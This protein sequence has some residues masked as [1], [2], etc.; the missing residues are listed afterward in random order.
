MRRKG[1][2]K[3]LKIKKYKY[4][5]ESSRSTYERALE[6]QLNCSSLNTNRYML[7]HWV[8]IHEEEEMK[9]GDFRIKLLKYTKSSFERQELEYYYKKTWIIICSTLK[10]NITDVTFLTLHLS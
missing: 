10:V 1:R 5:G 2:E 7:K 9:E 3:K 4:I 6:H 8:D